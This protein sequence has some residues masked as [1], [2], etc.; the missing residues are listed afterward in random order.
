MLRGGMKKNGMPII[1]VP[2]RAAGGKKEGTREVLLCIQQLVLNMCPQAD[3]EL[4][5]RPV[6]RLQ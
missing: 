1:C 5:P 2:P 4:T 6:T 3:S